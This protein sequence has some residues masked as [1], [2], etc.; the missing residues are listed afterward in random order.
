MNEQRIATKINVDENKD[1]FGY[2][3]FLFMFSIYCSLV[4]V[5]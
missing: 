5:G 1:I 3:L 4:H 2:C